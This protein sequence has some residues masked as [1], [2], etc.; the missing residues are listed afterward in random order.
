MLKVDYYGNELKGNEVSKINDAI[1]LYCLRNAE[2]KTFAE[3]IK[4]TIK[5]YVEIVN[6]MALIKQGTDEYAMIDKERTIF[7]DILIGNVNQLNR[8]AQ[9]LDK[10]LFLAN[11]ENMHRSEIGEEILIYEN[12]CDV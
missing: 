12:I 11:A 1:L 4:A 5:Y 2:Y 6:K 8:L 10:P 7:H 3:N 9:K